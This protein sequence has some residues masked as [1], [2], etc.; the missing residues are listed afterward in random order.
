MTAQPP[1]AIAAA[2]AT[3]AG[4]TGVAFQ[5]AALLPWR[6]VARN[7]ALPLE[8][9]GRDPAKYGHEIQKLIEL[10]GLNPHFPSKAL[11]SLS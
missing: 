4:V 6:S 8:V 10:V 5:D 7:V 9:L 3:A 11:I 1:G 2:T